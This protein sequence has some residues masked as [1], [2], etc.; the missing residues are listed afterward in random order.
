MI[1][2]YSEIPT[3]G[4]LISNCLLLFFSLD[5]TRKQGQTFEVVSSRI[6]GGLP[7]LINLYMIHLSSDFKKE[8][9][10]RFIYLKMTACVNLF[11]Y[12]KDFPPGI[13]M[14]REEKLEAI[15]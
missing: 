3:C 11:I 12:L 15:S 9:R 1:K 14:E 7:K 4:D 8:K 5:K 2:C 6:N 10:L 13:I